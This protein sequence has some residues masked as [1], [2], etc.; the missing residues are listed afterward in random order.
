M[1]FHGDERGVIISWFVKIAVFMSVLVVVLY[2]VGS[3]VVNE[4]S[5]DSTAD[6]IAIAVSL[7]VDEGGAS[8]TLFTDD[9]I[10]RLARAAAEED[11]ITGVKILKKG[12]EVDDEGIVHI[13]LRRRA[14][15]LVTKHISPLKKY[16]VATGDGQ[17]GTN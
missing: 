5:L 16:T 8:V 2:D 1:N 13:R 11:N 9:E 17:A 3:I 12:T 10:W 4:V 14:S 6:E 7:S 15:T